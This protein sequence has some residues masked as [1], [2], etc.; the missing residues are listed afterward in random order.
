MRLMVAFPFRASRGDEAI[1][2]LRCIDAA[3]ADRAVVT[4]ARARH[5]CTQATD[6]AAE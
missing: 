1:D 4:A 6:P 5:L 3:S 2:T